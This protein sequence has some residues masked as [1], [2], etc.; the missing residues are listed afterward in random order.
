MKA[1]FLLAVMLVSAK[2][3]SMDRGEAERLVAQR[4]LNLAT[5][6]RAGSQLLLGEVTGGGRLL[7]ADRVQVI[8]LDGRAVLKAEVVSMD[9]SPVTGRLSDLDSFRVG[10]TY[11]TREDIRGVVIR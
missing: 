6:E 3:F 10:G 4:S 11:H 2:A 8:L 7:P 9:F 1:F 5:L